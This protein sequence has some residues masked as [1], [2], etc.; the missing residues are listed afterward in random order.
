M[1]GL[2][3]PWRSLPCPTIPE[4]YHEIPGIHR[5]EV[6]SMLTKTKI[7]CAAHAIRVHPIPRPVRSASIPLALPSHQDLSNSCRAV[8]HHSPLPRSVFARK[9]ILP[10]C[11]NATNKPVRLPLRKCLLISRSM[12]R[13]R[14]HPPHHMKRTPKIVHADV[15]GSQRSELPY[16]PCIP[17]RIVRAGYQ[18]PTILCPI[19]RN[20]TILL[21]PGDN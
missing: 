17:S 21:L 1:Q 11:R 19:S 4:N 20:C 8:L 14:S 15:T 6:Q 10:I 3:C 13:K 9:I 18:S 12:G 2:P 7:F 5:L 16:F